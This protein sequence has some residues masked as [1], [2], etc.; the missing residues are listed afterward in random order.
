[1][2]TCELQY[3]AK[4]QIPERERNK[5]V[6]GKI[7]YILNHQNQGFWSGQVGIVFPR[8][9]NSILMTPSDFL[10]HEEHNRNKSGTVGGKRLYLYAPGA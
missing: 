1:M 5:P 7:P 6:V 3:F 4:L 2:H 9:P 10:S 8:F